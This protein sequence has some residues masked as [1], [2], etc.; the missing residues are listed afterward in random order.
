MAERQPKVSIIGDASRLVRAF[1]TASSATDKFSKGARNNSRHLD[2]LSTAATVAGAAVLGLAV[3]GL[4]KS[5]AAAV[6]AEASNARLAAQLTTMGKNSAVVRGQIDQTVQSLSRMSGFDDEQLQDA[7]TTLVR[8]TGN[9]SKSQQ[10]LGLVADIARGRQ[11]SLA[12]AAAIVNRVNVGNVGSLK[13]LGIEVDKNTT[14]QQAFGMLQQKFAGQAAAY[15]QTAAGAQERLGVAMENAFEAVG[16]A[17]TPLIIAF[18][19]WAA[20]VLP[21]VV[22]W[23]MQNKTAVLGV[24]AAMGGLWAALAGARMVNTFAQAFSVLN[25]VMKGNIFLL[26]AAAVVAVGAA[27]FAAYQKSATFRNAVNELLQAVRPVAQFLMSVAIVA[28]KGLA[29]VIE[30]GMAA[31]NKITS[32]ISTAWDALKKIG[33]WIK[34]A[35]N[36]VFGVLRD[37]VNVALTPILAMKA[38]VEW[39]ISHLPSISKANVKGNPL[40]G[41]SSN[42]GAGM[43]KANNEMARVANA[44]RS[45]GLQLGEGMKESIRQ[46]RSNLASMASG[47]ASQVGEAKRA[48]YRD[49]ATGMTIAQMRAAQEQVAN[50]RRKADLQAAIDGAQTDEDRA[51]AVRDMNDFVTEQNIAAAEAAAD[52]QATM[53]QNAIA[54]L[55]DQFNKGQITADE[56][57]TKLN[58]AIGGATG[59]ELGAAFA[60]EFGA[61]I[62]ALKK[63]IDELKAAAS[64]TGVTSSVQTPS[65]QADVQKWQERRSAFLKALNA[66]KKAGMTK[67]ER[68]RLLSNYG[69]DDLKEWDRENPKPAAALA[70]GGIATGPTFAMIGEA[71]AEA[72][73]PLEGPRARRMLRGANGIGSGQVTMVFNGVLNA[74]DA[75]RMLRPELDRLVRLAV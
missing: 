67:A 49:P 32:A 5:A 31:F 8:T 48:G 27:L 9:V 18:S 54:T 23:L 13:R 33:S 60:L 24:A 63:Q 47:V 68:T 10:E 69:A 34:S 72:V 44:A 61:N 46:A 1:R 73:I 28:F 22:N 12:Q 7:F 53:A 59:A 41:P 17:L 51:R 52:A 19:N 14:K 50:D 11:I 25:T 56:F 6:E 75:A 42:V 40:T 70:I 20:N 37:A 26:V 3:V 74:K 62:E 57:K 2:R 45:A 21:R 35:A 4:K 71:G 16:V 66:A 38:A 30:V 36:A 43:P 29:I 65:G 55:A 15:G 64:V 39:L 58:E